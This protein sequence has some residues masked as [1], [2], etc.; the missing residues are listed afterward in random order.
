MAGT[1][2]NSV[3]AIAPEINLLVE[4]V[5]RRPAC[6][7]VYRRDAAKSAATPARTKLHQEQLLQDWRLARA[8]AAMGVPVVFRRGQAGGS[9][10][11]SAIS[12]VS[13]APFSPIR[14]GTVA[15]A[16]RSIRTISA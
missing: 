4:P 14:S 1:K 3:E 10:P 8:G 2:P 7:T 9:M 13:R 16:S 15:P 11:S 5:R 6:S 12:I